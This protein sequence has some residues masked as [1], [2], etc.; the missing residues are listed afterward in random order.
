M[1]SDDFYRLTQRL[2]DVQFCADQTNVE[3]HFNLMTFETYIYGVFS[4]YNRIFSKIAEIEKMGKSFPELGLT[5]YMQVELDIYYYTLSYD[6]LSKIF[7]KIKELI[8]HISR[9]PNAKVKEFLKDYKILREKMERFFDHI[10]TN[11]RNEY[12]HPSM[13]PFN[14]GNVQVYK[15]LQDEGE[16]N[17]RFHVG[18]NDFA[19]VQKNHVDRLI[20]LRTELI[21]IFI[22]HFS[23]KPSTAELIQMKK[24]IEEEHEIGIDEYI[25]FQRDGKKDDADHLEKILLF[26]DAYLRQEGLPLRNDIKEK[27]FSYISKY[28]VDC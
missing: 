8:N 7:I 19:I 12:E 27:I 5:A 9:N 14:I 11:A 24:T 6:K 3:L 18:N 23:N 16:G 26:W 21:D 2:H 20:L 28:K 10:G 1:S 17:I 15:L 13:R 22:K 4:Q 25:Q